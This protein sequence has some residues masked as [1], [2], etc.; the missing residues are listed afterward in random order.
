MY[1]YLK[2]YYF[3]FFP[4]FFFLLCSNFCYGLVSTCSRMGIYW[5]GFL[6]FEPVRQSLVQ[7]TK[8]ASHDSYYMDAAPSI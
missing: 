5:I 1:C 6:T 8:V 4:F 7:A 3:T 2:L